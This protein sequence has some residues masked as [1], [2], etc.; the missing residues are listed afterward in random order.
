VCADQLPERLSGAEGPFT[1]RARADAK[2]RL[3][4]VVRRARSEGPQHITVHGRNAVVVVAEEE[5][6]RLKGKRTGAALVAAMQASPSSE[7]EIELG[8]ARM[9]VRAVDLS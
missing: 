1:R 8:R 6:R 5:F 7:I 4:E 3:S 2:A 9:P